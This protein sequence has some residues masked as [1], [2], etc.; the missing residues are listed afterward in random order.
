MSNPSFSNIDLWLFELAEG[1]LTPR[2][3][4]QLELFLLQNPDLDIDRDMWEMAKVEKQEAVFPD[5]EK[6]NKRRPIG[7][8]FAGSTAIVASI[9]FAWWAFAPSTLV[10]SDSLLMA[11]NSNRTKTRVFVIH[12]T[13]ASVAANMQVADAGLNFNAPELP[14]PQLAQ[15]HNNALP[16][17]ANV[18]PGEFNNAQSQT[19]EIPGNINGLDPQALSSTANAGEIEASSS[20]SQ[21]GNDQIGLDVA[22]HSGEELEQENR[23]LESINS[24]EIAQLEGFET[25][26]G[27][28]FEP[29]EGAGRSARENDEFSLV[30]GL[31]NI[32]EEASNSNQNNRVSFSNDY[33]NSLKSRLSAFGRKIK[34][35]LD[36]PVALKNYRD[37]AYHIPG[38]LPSDINFGAT[39]T[40]LS[41]RVQTL[42]R[43][44]WYDQD[45][46]QLINQ[47]AVDAYA[48]NLRGGI[49]LQIEHGM[50]KNGGVSVAQAAITYSPKFSISR[51]ISFEPSLRFKMGNKTLANSKMAGVNRVEVDRG[52]DFAYYPESQPI[53]KML[54]HHDLGAGLMVNTEWFFVGVQMDNFFRHQDNIYAVDVENPKRAEFHYLATLGTDWVSRRENL[55]LSP[56]LVYQHNGRLSEAWLGANFRWNWLTVGASVSS[57]M[58]PAASLGLKFEHF[59]MTYSAD[60]TKSAM[61]GQAALSHQL[62]LRFV[63]KPSRFGKRLLNL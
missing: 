43:L 36:N 42:S 34:R 17:N 5:Q 2:Q 10:P 55:S 12:R 31:D 20:E 62:T 9:V 32:G 16:N 15:N 60:Y 29:F 33:K 40:M 48:Y 56:Y 52:N 19:N 11:R 14:N 49:G 26:N 51:T 39:G 37:P 47:L 38:M 3:I 50:Y 18:T 61:T 59:A 22:L 35:T 8:Y 30:D 13:D 24:L 4:E 23:S 28:D 45:N 21:L 6:L 7:W 58:E 44:Q 57:F 1:N 41:T 63:S 54:W 46:E 53:G 27:N 25:I